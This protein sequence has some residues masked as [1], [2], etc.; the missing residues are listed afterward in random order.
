MRS[1]LAE[2][3]LHRAEILTSGHQARVLIADENNCCQEVFYQTLTPTLSPNGETLEYN[4]YQTTNGKQ[5]TSKSKV[6]VGAQA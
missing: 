3:S 1:L 2:A 4:G 6:M 5:L